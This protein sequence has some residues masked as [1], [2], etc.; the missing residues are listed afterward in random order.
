MNRHRPVYQTSRS[1][2]PASGPVATV[3]RRLHGHA[4]RRDEFAATSQHIP[5]HRLSD[6]QLPTGGHSEILSAESKFEG[7]DGCWVTYVAS[8]SGR[9]RSCPSHQSRCR[10]TMRTVQKT[11]PLPVPRLPFEVISTMYG[12]VARVLHS[13]GG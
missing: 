10:T 6:Y 11:P 2:I 7:D 5:G 8:A 13:A 4:F 9:R 3:W 1:R 12:C